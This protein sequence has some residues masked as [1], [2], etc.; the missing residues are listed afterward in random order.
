MVLPKKKTKANS[1]YTIGYYSAILTA[2]L[3]LVALVFIRL[4]FGIENEYRFDVVAISINWPALLITGILQGILFGKVIN[5]G[6]RKK[7]Q[8]SPVIDQPKK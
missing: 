3:T 4:F 5:Y 1:L 6:R 7:V 8:A 2:G